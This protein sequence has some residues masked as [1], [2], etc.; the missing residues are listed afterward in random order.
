MSAHAE[1]PEWLLNS[2]VLVVDDNAVY[3]HLMRLRLQAVGCACH[4]SGT[5]EEPLEL[6]GI[7][8]NIKAVIVDYHV[9]SVDVDSLVL[10]I[11]RSWPDVVIVGNSNMAHAPE[12]EELGV[13]LFLRK[14]WTNDDLFGV[15]GQVV[16]E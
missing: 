7:H 14:P 2:G 11:K 5:P 10:D 1:P 15:L 3:G 9:G 16:S 4:R 8:P 12:F 13:P 6:L